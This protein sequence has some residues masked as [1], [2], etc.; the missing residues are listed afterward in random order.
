MGYKRQLNL[1]SI[2]FCCFFFVEKLN[3]ARGFGQTKL[4]V[5]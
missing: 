4:L 5:F 3:I 2:T 1:D